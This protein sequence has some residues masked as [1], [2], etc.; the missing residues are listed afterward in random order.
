MN[1][2]DFEA[3]ANTPSGYSDNYSGGYSEDYQDSHAAPLHNQPVNRPAN[4]Q[5]FLW[6]AGLITLPY[7]SY[8]GLLLLLGLLIRAMGQRGKQVWQ[9]CAQRGFGWLTLGLLLSASFAQN[10]GEAFL[11]LTNFLP[12]FLFF[13]VLATVPGVVQ[14]P[15]AKL[16]SVAR[17]LLLTAVPTS[18]LAI[19]EFGLKFDGVALWMQAQPLPN[20]LLS[21]IY[22][23][24]FGHRAHSIFGHPNG[25]SAYLVIIFG[26][27]LGLFLKGLST[28][29]LESAATTTAKAQVRV[30][31]QKQNSL[32]AGALGLC[33]IAIFC[34]GSR[35]G[36]LIALV[37]VAIALYTARRHR[38]VMLTGLASSGAIIAA[39]LSLGIGGRSLSLALI[40]QDPRISIWHMALEMIQQRPFLGWGFGGLRLLYIPGS[41]PDYDVV[42]HAHNIWLFL[43]SEAGIPVMLGFCAVISTLYYRGV[44]TF[45]RWNTDFKNAEQGRDALATVGSNGQQNGQSNDPSN[46]LSIEHQSSETFQGDRAILLG[47]LLAF[48]SCLMFGLFDV[49]LFDSRINILSWG[50]LAAIYMMSNPAKPNG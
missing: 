10:R 16:E 31:L 37:L 8:A 26:L 25:L 15:F 18:I 28:E 13:G 34:T 19:V 6:L 47:Y 45:I 14:Q 39:V 24:D 11:Q 3:I 44:R 48:S 1:K 42:F 30:Q 9:L 40:T 20:W 36:V 17:W 32:Q 7:V 41:I 5:E 43:A 4:R 2:G 12:F 23:P 27:G 49:T 38:W 35:N 50:L 22:E 29:R 46:K 33:A 21:W